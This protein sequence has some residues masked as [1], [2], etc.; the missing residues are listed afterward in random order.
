MSIERG[1]KKNEEFMES[2]EIK[3]KKVDEYRSLI[4]LNKWTGVIN[5]DDTVENIFEIIRR[6]LAK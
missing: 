5:A 3:R 1:L 2:F 4:T 6:E